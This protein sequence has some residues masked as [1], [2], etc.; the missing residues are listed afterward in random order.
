[1]GSV[2]ASTIMADAAET[3][4]DTANTR[5][6]DLEKFRY[7]NA[8]QRLLCLYKPDAYALID[9]YRLVQ[10]TKQ[11]V[12]DGTRVFERPAKS[13]DFVDADV[14]INNALPEGTLDTITEADHGFEMGDKVRL[15]NA[16]GA[17]PTGL[18]A[19]TT[20]YVIALDPDTIALASSM[21]NAL[22]YTCVEITAA[23]GGGTHTVARYDRAL[24]QAI[25]LIR[26]VRNMGTDGVTVGPAIEHCDLDVLD[27][28]NPDWHEASSN[29]EVQ[30]VAYDERFPKQFFV[31]PPQ[32]SDTPGW[33]QIAYSAL[34]EDIIALYSGSESIWDADAD[35]F[36]AGTYAWAANGTNTIA[37]ASNRLRVTY[38]DDATGA[39]VNLNDAADLSEDL[40][41]GL[42][43]KLTFDAYCWNSGGGATP[44]TIRLSVGEGASSIQE[45]SEYLSYF[46]TT[47][48]VEFEATSATAMRLQLSGMVPD[49]VVEIDNL[50]LDKR[51]DYDVPINLADKYQ[52]A[53]RYYVLHRC[54]EKNSATSPYDAARSVE[55][56]NLFV[57]E[58]GRLDLLRK[59][60]GPNRKER[61]A[62]TEA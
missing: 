12:P 23:A 1:M 9:T 58:I 53:L 15:T 62:N 37:N 44:T 41:P 33:I 22:S 39:Y 26:A 46:M 59:A 24:A 56:W 61:S 16:G 5:W 21:G 20:Y 48:E 34:V 3:L 29:A 28:F 30:A 54:Y 7:L 50:S 10:G 60:T 18:A 31:Y 42:Y 52:S 57:T 11:R 25:R 6:P 55:Y 47:Y 51:D 17:L 38:V 43:Y 4:L 45:Y 19:A 13:F 14:T 2:L 35:V 8:G 36:T 32:P 49:S 40:V 27:S